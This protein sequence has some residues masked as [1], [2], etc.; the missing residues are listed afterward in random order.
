VRR[1]KVEHQSTD[2]ALASNHSEE[3]WHVTEIST[4]KQITVWRYSFK[5]TGFVYF[6]CAKCVTPRGSQ[7][8]DCKH[9]RA[10]KRIV[11]P[12]IHS[13]QGRRAR[14]RKKKGG[15]S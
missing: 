9:I 6:V 2:H 5:K 14:E 7:A 15:D 10:V 3:T 4:D 13:G 1:W 11:A 12:E 8:G